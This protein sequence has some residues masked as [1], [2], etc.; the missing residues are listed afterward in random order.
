MRW[1]NDGGEPLIS[2]H[3]VLLLLGFGVLI[4]AAVMFQLGTNRSSWPA[5]SAQI[6][7]V[8]TRCRMS[9]ME[10]RY[11][12]AY[13]RVVIGCDQVDRFRADNANRRWRATRVYSGEVAVTRDGQ[14]VRFVRA[15]SLADVGTVPVVG[16]V[17]E[18]VQNPNVP[19]D[20]SRPSWSLSEMMIGSTL[21]GLGAFLLAIAFFWV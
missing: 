9:A 21:A 8:E 20:V 4:V 17:F 1:Y 14:T 2:A 16:G 6:L 15:L 11:R 18:V 3:A 7:S 5:A 13:G 19:T 10:F 12:R